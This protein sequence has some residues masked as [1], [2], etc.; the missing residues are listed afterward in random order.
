MPMGNKDDV[1]LEPVIPIV[2]FST[3]DNVR[4]I[5]ECYSA[6]CNSYITKP[7]ELDEFNSALEH[8]AAYWLEVSALP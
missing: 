5:K 2:V 7:S 8:V 6:G 4:D 1:D 3:S